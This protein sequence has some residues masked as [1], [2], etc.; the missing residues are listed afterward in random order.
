MSVFSSGIVHCV[1]H[2]GSNLTYE[3]VDE[4]LAQYLPVGTLELKYYTKILLS[5]P[6]YF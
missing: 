3:C 5:F 6:C 2:E 1:V 4:I